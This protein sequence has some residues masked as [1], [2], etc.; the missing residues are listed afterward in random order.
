MNLFLTPQV[1]DKI[2]NVELACSEAMQ[3]CKVVLPYIPARDVDILDVRL[4][5]AK[6]GFSTKAGVAR[7][8]HDLA[9][10]ELQAMELGLRSLYEF[11]EA[12][13]QFREELLELTLSEARH[14]T[15]CLEG[16]DTLGFKWGDWPVH[17]ALW[18]CVDKTDSLLDRI[19]I[20]HR[21][22]EG[23]GL[24]AGDKFLR[25]LDGVEAK[26]EYRIVKQ[27]N[28]EEIDHVAFGSR[29]YRQICQIE[30]RDSQID[31]PERMKSLLRRLP[32]RREVINRELRLKSGFIP[33][34]IDY[35]EK[36]RE[37]ILAT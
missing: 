31:F 12:P 23:S 21:Y 7:L 26:L 18:H 8:L 11:P 27:I 24:D 36:L 1:W 37:S 33:S 10:I 34:E 13:A 14:L 25:R 15:M 9:S 17:L 30:K 35:L 5:P 32:R 20:V 19:L 4:H 29:W 22:L 16:I 28:T 2:K 3:G 6:S